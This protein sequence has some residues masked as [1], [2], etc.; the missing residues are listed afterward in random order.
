[1]FSIPEHVSTEA[2]SSIQLMNLKLE[3]KYLRLETSRNRLL[4]ELEGLDEDL[5]NTPA[6]VGKWSIIQHIAH[7]LLVDKVT[8]GYVQHKLRQQE[9]LHTSSISQSFKSLLL[10]LALQSGKKYKA[11]PAVANV[12]D[13]AS[14]PELRQEWD[15][16]RFKLEDVLTDIPPHLLDKCLFK[17]PYVGPLTT[18]Q[19]LTFLQDHFDHHLRAIH[20]LK[21][22]LVS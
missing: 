20:H 6:A 1:M 11:P 14:L 8:M 16:I 10:K 2:S 9:Q 13:H 15:D 5:L 18:S 3:A 17:H 7:L 22:Q 21:H 19:A 12:P 4:D